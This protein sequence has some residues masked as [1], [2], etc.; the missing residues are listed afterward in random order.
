MTRPE[1]D[2]ERQAIEASCPFVSI[3]DERWGLLLEARTGKKT[4]A[5]ESPPFVYAVL[6]TGVYCRLGCR[7]RLPL[8]DN[9]RF[10]ESGVTAARAGYRPCKRCHPERERP[11]E[12]DLL[13]RAC[14]RIERAEAPLS[15]A[16]Q[17]R[18]AGLSSSRFH[19]LFRT[20]TG[21]TP[22]QYLAAHQRGRLKRSLQEGHPV[23]RAIHDA[24]FSSPSRVYENT[25]DLLGMSPTAYAQGGSGEVVRI[26]FA[27]SS[28]GWVLVASTE[29]GIC[30]VELGTHRRALARSLEQRFPKA[31]RRALS[32]A[33]RRWLCEVVREID[34]GTGQAENSLP[35]DI[36][37]TVFQVR[38][39]MALRTI[40]RG[41]TVTYS[42]LAGKLGA[43]RA[44]RAVARA[45]AANRL[46]VLIPCHRVVRKDGALGGYQWGLA[47]KRTLLAR[48][49]Q[50]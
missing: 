48:E 36:R 20:H 47:R 3:F 2:G 4:A 42:K 45:C 25:D 22:K 17:A 15:L 43:P 30:A 8:R 9:V 1:S 24:G 6:T 7:S 33:A 35:L 27:R 12:H 41:Q 28:L 46:A 32:P 31:R 40:P 38:V 14:R 44:S 16:E 39:W 29:R 10:F 23:T 21:I 11:L 26:G 49:R 18:A 50:G 5:S 19:K 37:G 34:H 13:E